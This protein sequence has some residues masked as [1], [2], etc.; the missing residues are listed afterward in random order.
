MKTGGIGKLSALAL[1]LATGACVGAP[2]LA[3]TELAAT[4]T[5]QQQTPGPGD[6]DGTGT[7]RIRLDA[8]AG[9]LCW[10]VNARGIGRATSAAIHR[11]AAG[12][13]G[14]L[15]VS[16]TAPDSAGRSQGCA[17]VP[18]QEARQMALQAHQFYL[19]V[20]DEAHPAGAIR[21]QLSGGVPPPEPRRRPIRR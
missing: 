13:T 3:R 5:G 19:V 12:S 7:A 6:S 4:L 16:L 15:V 2:A 14:P 10:E 11:A 8:G 9:R 1:L 20:A 21:G 17:A 18:Q